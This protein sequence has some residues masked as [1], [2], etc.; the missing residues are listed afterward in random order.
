[1]LYCEVHTSEWWFLHGRC[2][3][4]ILILFLLGNCLKSSSKD[5]LVWSLQII[6]FFAHTEEE[7]L[8]VLEHFSF[9]SCRT[10]SIVY[11]GK[12]PVYFFLVILA[13]LAAIY[14]SL[15]ATI[16]SAI[17]LT[18]FWTACSQGQSLRQYLCS[19]ANKISFQSQHRDPSVV[20]AA[21]SFEIFQLHMA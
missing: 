5:M 19:Y 4:T 16:N 10:R 18:C 6:W 9:L 21:A 13:A 8:P 2:V 17:N 15:L 20:T 12:Y 11:I 1:M 7:S 3:W 14:S